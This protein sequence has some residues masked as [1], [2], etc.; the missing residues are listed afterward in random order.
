MNREM[1][2]AWGKYLEGFADWSAFITMTF[3]EK[4]RTHP[5]T[6]SEAEFLWRRLVQVLNRDLFGK[7]YTRIVHHSYFAYA[8]GFEQ[9]PWGLLHMHALTDRRTN[10]E[11]INTM[12][13]RM[14]GIVKV[15]RV[16]AIEGAAR[17]V[18]K[19]AAKSGDVI[20]YRP[21]KLKEPAFKPMWYEQLDFAKSEPD[22]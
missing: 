13:R 3:S 22:D 7:R 17:Y 9:Q 18:S 10:W 21:S 15:E 14:A 1:H 8:L 4:D 2:D 11:L 20:L 16:T 6:Q 5:V 19:Y 12:W